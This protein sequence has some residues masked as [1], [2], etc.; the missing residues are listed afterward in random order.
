MHA[1]KITLIGLAALA[2]VAGAVYLA[3][4]AALHPVLVWLGLEEPPPQPK[5]PW[6]TIEQRLAQIEPASSERLKVKFAA[7]GVAYPPAGVTL[8][9]LKAEK[10]LQLYARAGGK[11]WRLV[12]SYPVL[13]ASG[14][15][16]PKLREGDRQVPEGLYDIDLLN[17]NSKFSVS[18]RVNYPNDFDRAMA[19]KEKRRDPLGGAIMIHGRASSIGCLAMGDPAAEELFVLAHA[20]GISQVKVIIAPVD[21]RSKPWPKIEK[22]PAWLNG[23]Y[24]RIEAA[25]ELFPIPTN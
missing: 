25:L 6:L 13:A 11:E 23:L 16:G 1:L 24:G 19:A 4:P 17:P 12:H 10:R 5:P 7:A 3:R 14:T 22:A 2:V 15:H 18:M 21:F 8:V 9:G 20:I